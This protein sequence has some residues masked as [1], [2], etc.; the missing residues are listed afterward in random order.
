VAAKSAV[1]LDDAGRTIGERYV[2]EEPLGRGG[3]AAVYRVRDLRSGAKVA[4]KRAWTPDSRKLEKR[5][6][7]LEREYHTLAQLKHPRIIEV[8]DYGVDERGPYYTMELLDGADLDQGVQLPWRE[9]C[10]LLHDIASSLAI[11]HSRGLLHRDVSSRNVRRTAD[12]RA[13]LIDFG[14]MV[15]MGVAKEVVGT[16]PFTAPEVLQMQALDARA[17]L[18]ALGALGYYLL[19]GRHAYPARRLSDL[20]DVWRS[21]P[22]SPGR[23]LAELPPALNVLIMQLLALERSGR[24]QSA[25]EVME[26]LCA[27]A[28]LPMQEGIEISRAYLTTPTLVGRDK[29]LALIRSR[30]LSLVRGD[31]GGLLLEGAAG[32]GRSRMLDACAFE[33]K[34][35]GA[36]VAR[37]D[38]GDGA[39]GEWGV[40]RALCTQLL[41]LLPAQA[42]QAAR[43]SRDVLGHVL[44]SL[45]RE[46]SSSS[47]ASPPERSLLLRELRDFVLVLTQGQRLLLVIDDADRIDE[48][49]AALLAALADKAE[50]HSLMLALAVDAES[51]R[52][53][54]PSLRLLRSLSHRVELD[55]LE[56]TQTEALVRSLFGDTANL[57][58]CAGPIHALAQGNAGTTMELAQHLVSRGLARYEAGSWLLPASLAEG[59]LPKTLT[60]SL[61][62]RLDEL[63][64]DALELCEVL[65]IADGHSLGLSS[66]RVLTTHH[67]QKRVFRALD[68]L[69]AARVLVADA[70]RYRFGQRGFAAVL[71]QRPARARQIA[72]HSRLADLLASSGGDVLGRAHHLLQANRELE[73]IELLSTIDL[74]ARLP[75]LLLLEQALGGAE[76]HALLPRAIHR[77]RMAV[78]IKAGLMMAVD[79]FRRVLPA[80]LAQLEHDSGLVLYGELSA[81]PVQER[82]SQALGQAQARYLATPEAERVHPVGD[83]I[84][85]LA[86][87]SSAT[88]AIAT[89]MFDLELL[90][91]LP[92]LGPLTPLSPAMHVV[93]QLV[94]AGKQWVRGRRHRSTELYEQVLARI[95]QPD[96]GGL[97]HSQHERMRLGVQYGLA[98]VDASLGA[99]AAEK[100]A[101]V[102]DGHRQMRVSAWRVRMIM[103][104][105]QGN[106]EAARKCMRRAELLQLQD[107]GESWFLGTS[108]GFELGAAH[109]ADDLLGVKSAVDALTLL[110]QRHAGWKPMLYFGLGS[111]RE[112]QGDLEGALD[113]LLAGLELAKPARHVNYFLLAAAQVRVLGALGRLDEALACGRHHLAIC[114][115]EELVP[116]HRRIQL[117]L[118]LVLAR[119]GEHEQA[120]ELI[121]LVIAWGE[122]VGLSGLALGVLYE[123]RARIAIWMQDSAAFEHFAELCASEYQKGKNPALG[124]KFARLLED[125]RQHRISSTAPAHPLIELVER[126]QSETESNFIKSRILECVD[127]NDRA[128]CALTLILQSTESSAGYLY[129]VEPQAVTLL[130]ALPETPAEQGLED[131]LQRCVR[132]ELEG[133]AN[134]TTGVGG[135]SQEA[136]EDL[137]DRYTDHEGRSFEAIFLIGEHEQEER[138]AAVLALHVAPGP[139]RVPSKYLC[140]E[141]A[142]QL[143]EQGDATGA[144]LRFISATE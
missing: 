104:L 63:S 94:Q 62:G 5:R 9:V 73:A 17:D 114:E 3:M 126:S 27:I 45:R 102:L 60:A 117:E 99:D 88:C 22:A 15:S 18:Y 142:S 57:Q 93:M 23:M 34:L 7:L 54:T 39:A 65:C 121:G 108:A 19:T 40:A 115:R 90:E 129:G 59:D 28:S 140:F 98:L 20:R 103:H 92:D 32:S 66:Y 47:S 70:E 2:V 132:A 6:A 85:E 78:L 24:P 82:L 89:S 137:A 124:A 35:L 95:A 77:L 52:E 26:R 128:R 138:I 1:L 83:A 110:V 12:G 100:R 106:A 79:S 134:A 81:L 13:K 143:L 71:K 97:D 135:D 125:A 36:V 123:A 139:R 4:L 72:I 21:R 43:L 33:G 58:L 41:E 131:W 74:V 76:R 116:G 37:A 50:R 49:S 44:E 109:A 75:P 119:A 111:Y 14:A 31:G 86:Q 133:I 51:E 113:A 96:R 64:A 55:P 30:M 29:A 48:P 112:L 118:A 101:A 67:D 84:R 56:P 141:I 120:L 61:E 91:S 16:P 144:L 69:V 46:A 8:Y 53:S 11:L 130:A 80:V 107:G 42:A 38:A 87:L 68:E 122:G 25:A 105:N 127:R 136:Q 10:A